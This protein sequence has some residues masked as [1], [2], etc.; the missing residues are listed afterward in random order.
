MTD[1]ELQILAVEDRWH[2]HPGRKLQAIRKLGVTEIRYYQ[3]LNRLVD[4][5]EAERVAALLIH[6]LRRIRDQRRRS[7]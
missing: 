7:A 2:R 1:L 3:I 4:D 5:P 6:R